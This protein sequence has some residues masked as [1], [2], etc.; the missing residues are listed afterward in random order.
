MPLWPQELL[1][2][3]WSLMVQTA[4]NHTEYL[5]CGILLP[6]TL[7][8]DSWKL[9]L[10]RRLRKRKGCDVDQVPG[11]CFKCDFKKNFLVT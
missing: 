1:Q 2:S 4:F 9:R 7:P 10:L 3:S 8:R 6:I 11:D 5:L